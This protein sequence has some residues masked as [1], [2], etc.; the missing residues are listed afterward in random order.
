MASLT[1]TNNTTRFLN[2]QQTV[3]IDLDPSVSASNVQVST[4]TTV[5]QGNQIVWSNFSLSSGQQATATVNLVSAGGGASIAMGGLAIRSVSVEAVDRQTG[6]RVSEQAQ[7]AGEPVMPPSTA[8]LTMSGVP[9]TGASVSVAAA[10]PAP[11]LTSPGTAAVNA[12]GAGGQNS[13]GANV[14]PAIRAP[15][16]GLGSTPANATTAIVPGA[17]PVAAA[18]ATGTPLSLPRAGDP[19]PGAWILAALCGALALLCSGGFLVQRPWPPS[20]LIK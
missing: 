18:A 20:R 13:V 10:T 12:F 5:I 8:P 19:L 17:Q 3:V 7:T 14:A 9:S 6:E 2:V 1:V 4:G 16:A 11:A 15:S